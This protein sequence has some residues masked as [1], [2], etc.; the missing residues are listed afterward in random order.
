MILIKVMKLIKIYKINGHIC[1]DIDNF[2][3]KLIVKEELLT[4]TKMETA[5]N[6]GKVISKRAPLFSFWDKE[7]R[8]CM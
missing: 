4:N 8:R 5:K 7:K 6:Y 2:N 1:V 3:F